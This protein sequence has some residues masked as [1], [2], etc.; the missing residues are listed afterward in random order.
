M[1]RRGEDNNGR[2]QL[3][4]TVATAPVPGRKRGR[5]GGGKGEK[6][7]EGIGEEGN[8]GDGERGKRQAEGRE[9]ERQQRKTKAGGNS[10][11]STGTHVTVNSD[12]KQSNLTRPIPCKQGGRI[13]SGPQFHRIWRRSC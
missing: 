4:E 13:T 11:K 12:S 5:D 9:G 1:G 3:V 2:Q 10:S 7:K 8:G 6:G